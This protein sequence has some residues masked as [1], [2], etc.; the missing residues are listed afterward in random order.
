M[1]QGECLS[2]EG[3]SQ[4]GEGKWIATCKLWLLLKGL[5]VFVYTL[6]ILC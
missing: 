3:I 5:L 2:Q 1:T 4:C 6:L